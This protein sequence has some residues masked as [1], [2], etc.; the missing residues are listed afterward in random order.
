MKTR[1]EVRNVGTRDETL[2]S[3]RLCQIIDQF[4]RKNSENVF[5]LVKISRA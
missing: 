3:Y 4:L 5:K 1:K 2:T